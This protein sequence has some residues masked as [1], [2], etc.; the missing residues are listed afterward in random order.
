MAVA[1]F[2]TISTDVGVVMPVVTAISGLWAAVSAG[3]P[4]IAGIVALLGGPLTIAIGAIS[5]AIGVLTAAWTQNW[6]GIQEKTAA[7]INWFTGTAWP[8]VQA[9]FMVAGTWLTSLQTTWN[10]VFAS[11][12]GYIDGVKTRW[13]EFVTMIK[14]A[15]A[16][17]ATVFGPIASA[18]GGFGS[19]LSSLEGKLPW[20]LVPHS[21]TPLE[22]ALRGVASAIGPAGSALGDLGKY[23]RFAA[24]E[25][26]WLNDWLTH[27]PAGAH[28]AALALG[29]MVEAG[30]ITAGEALAGVQAH[31]GNLGEQIP[32]GRGAGA[33]GA[34]GAP[35]GTIGINIYIDGKPADGRVE[36]TGGWGNFRV[37]LNQ[38][39]AT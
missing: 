39:A 17:I 29:K 30:S 38:M 11:I 2:A 15:G 14:T 19:V 32:A 7:V 35:G 24:S 37:A 26:D 12:Q 1:A 18:F 8:A 28:D 25:G 22:N 33:A 36:V 34:G 31:M 13:N 9:A 6:F 10:T 27:L 5:L 3:T 21:P 4:I 20:W 23:L 16:G